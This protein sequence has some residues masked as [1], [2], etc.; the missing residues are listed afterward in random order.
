MRYTGCN[1]QI[2]MFYT[3]MLTNRGKVLICMKCGKVLKSCKCLTL[4]D[5]ILGDSRIE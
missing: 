2:M 3:V 1:G 4:M 5:R